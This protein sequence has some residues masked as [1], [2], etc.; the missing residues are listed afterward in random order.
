MAKWEVVNGHV[1]IPEGVTTIG[2]S[3]FSGCTGLTSISISECVTEIK[4]FA[5]FDCERITSVKIPDGVTEIGMYAFNI[6]YKEYGMEA[7]QQLIAEIKNDT[8]IS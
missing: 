1:D 2:V 6:G 8:N 3:A 7:T 4:P 5:F